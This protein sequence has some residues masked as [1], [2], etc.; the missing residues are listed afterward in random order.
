MYTATLKFLGA[1]GEMK[2]FQ[3]QDGGVNYKQELLFET[4]EANQNIKP[5][6]VVLSAWNDS[7]NIFAAAQSGTAF[8]V[9]AFVS[10]R[11]HNG[12]YYTD[13]KLWK[14]ERSQTQTQASGSAPAAVTPAP[15]APASQQDTAN[16]TSDTP[17]AS[18][19]SPANAGDTMD[20]LPF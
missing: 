11:E 14:A 20:D 10:S 19:T 3:K 6:K 7:I 1:A 13:I 17:P 8:D 18:I 5:S 16:I 15:V 4:I 2:T 12:K 9:R